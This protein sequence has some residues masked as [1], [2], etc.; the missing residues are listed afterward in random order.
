MIKRGFDVIVSL[1][2]L[3][4]LLPLGL[5]ISLLVK[6]DGP[7]PVFFRQPRVGQH[8]REFRIHKFR[9]MV[10]D[11]AQRGPALTMADDARVTR[12]GAMLRRRRLDELPQFIDVLMGSMS[13]V[14]P[15]PEVPRFAATVRA[16]LR[17][18]WLALKPGMTDPSSLAHIDE[19]AML[20]RSADPERLYVEQILPAK[21]QA[22]VDYARG[23]TLASDLC[24]L[25]RT[26]R[27]LVRR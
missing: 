24:V 21:V 2:A 13:L 22:S 1:M 23:A 12:V 7:G 10:P 20:A 18:A 27:M 17:D 26:L 15:R 3:L 11:A 16:P 8:G 25:A 14:G 5:V 19:D 4:L 9:T 6:L